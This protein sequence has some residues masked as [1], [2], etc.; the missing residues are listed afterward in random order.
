MIFWMNPD[1]RAPYL[2]V[3]LV[4]DLALEGPLPEN[5]VPIRV[6]QLPG[7][8]CVAPV[9]GSAKELELEGMHV[10]N[11]A[12]RIGWYALSLK[13]YAIIAGLRSSTPATDLIL[14]K[15]FDEFCNFQD[16][17]LPEGCYYLH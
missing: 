6:Y 15:D 1:G 3:G 9:P 12:P 14:S 2:P 17:A 11:V 10:N 5:A 8:G 13:D 4:K 16:D 7:I